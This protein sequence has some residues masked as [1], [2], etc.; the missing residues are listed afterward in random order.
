MYSEIGGGGVAGRPRR[1]ERL[2]FVCLAVT[3][4][5][6][7]GLLV[8]A[9]SALADGPPQ[10]YSD[11]P[12]PTD[13][14]GASGDSGDAANANVR[15]P[16]QQAA[17][18][19]TVALA[20]VRAKTTTDCANQA[21]HAQRLHFSATV[22]RNGHKGKFTYF[23]TAQKNN[24][25]SLSPTWVDC[26]TADYQTTRACGRWKKPNRA[27]TPPDTGRTTRHKHYARWRAPKLGNG[28][29][30]V[31]LILTVTD[32]SGGSQTADY[33]VNYSELLPP[34]PAAR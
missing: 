8:S 33:R 15:T 11:D 6:S 10:T 4:A 19:W 14:S 21:Y 5:V 20:C 1:I 22:T 7:I 30:N 28:D 32:T 27:N 13:T 18:D 16:R 9:S 17:P 2:L 12:A 34:P 3:A 31:K 24:G 29:G 26:V 23:W 25:P